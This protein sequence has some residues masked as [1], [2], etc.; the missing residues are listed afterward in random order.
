MKV[1]ARRPRLLWMR[2]VFFSINLMSDLQWVWTLF[3]FMPPFDHNNG[4][5]ETGLKMFMFNLKLSLP[6]FMYVYVQQKK[7]GIFFRLVGVLDLVLHVY[8]R[9]N[10]GHN[11]CECDSTTKEVSLS[12]NN[13][14][15]LVLKE[16]SCFN[17]FSSVNFSIFM[18]F[19]VWILWYPSDIIEIREC[20]LTGSSML[21]ADN[22]KRM[23]VPSFP[24]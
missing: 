18:C 9:P 21:F 13:G 3:K 16:Y 8:V 19:V 15:N 22:A 11:G 4:W 14:L 1:N 2:P 5:G 12:H 17:A 6:F 10:L 23:T 20:P 7:S 24:S